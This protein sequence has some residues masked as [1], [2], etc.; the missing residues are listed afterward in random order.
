[1]GSIEMDKWAVLLDKMA[2]AVTRQRPNALCQ[3]DQDL[4]DEKRMGLSAT[5]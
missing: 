5:T 4:R 1:M 3:A 2:Q